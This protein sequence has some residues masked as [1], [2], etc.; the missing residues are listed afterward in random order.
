MLA[1]GTAPIVVVSNLSPTSSSKEANDKAHHKRGGGFENPWEAF[2]PMGMNPVTMYQLYKDWENHPVPP[3]ER[4]PPLMTPQFTPSSSLSPQE[5]EEWSNDLKVTSLGHACFLVEFPKSPQQE[6]GLRVLFDP[7]WSHRCSPSQ[8]VGPARVAKPPIKLEDIPHVDAVV[9]SHNHYD[10]LDIATLKHLYKAQPK[11][12]IHFFAPLG[13]KSWFMSNIGCSESQ[14]TEIDWWETRDL[15]LSNGAGGGEDSLKVT[16]TPC[17]HF[18]G[19]GIFDRNDTLWSSWIVEKNNGGK[20][21]FA[22]DTGYK[23]IPRGVPMEE[24]YKFP[25]CPAFKEIGDKEGPFDVGLIPIGAVEPRFFMS[26]IHCSPEDA[27]ELHR[28]TRS[29][30]S[31]GMHHSTWMLTCEPMDEPPKRLRKACEK[32]GISEEEFGVSGLGETKRFKVE[33][34]E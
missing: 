21:W 19:R 4:L 25:H 5:L 24:E 3:P 9:I 28:E 15:T 2:V 1:A 17:M 33:P 10:H 27:V 34:R 22:G 8:L 18:T 14:V 11:D 12:S 7:V 32:Y 29:R 13:N 30:K 16:A 31:L 26:R 6:R 23:S 20:V